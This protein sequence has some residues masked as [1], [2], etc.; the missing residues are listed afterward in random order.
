MN[1]QLTASLSARPVSSRPQPANGGGQ[2]NAG[3]PRRGG[4]GGGPRRGG[5]GGGRGGA[6]QPKVVKSAADLDAELDAHNAKM[7]TD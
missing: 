2:R 5:R 4:G 7:Q 3:P 6:R 1:I